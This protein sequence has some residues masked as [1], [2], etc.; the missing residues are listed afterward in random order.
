MRPVDAAKVIAAVALVTGSCLAALAP[1]GVALYIGLG[2][3]GG[4]FFWSMLFVII[5]KAVEVGARAACE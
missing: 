5:A 4:V 2:I 1:H 3:A